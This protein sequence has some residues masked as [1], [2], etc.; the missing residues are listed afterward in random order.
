MPA[1]RLPAP[2]DP[3]LRATACFDGGDYGGGACE[4]HAAVEV[5]AYGGDR[6]A[7]VAAPAGAA[8]HRWVLRRRAARGLP[9]R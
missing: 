7:C 9:R 3:A 2:G 8:L 6:L 1:G 5:A 4:Y